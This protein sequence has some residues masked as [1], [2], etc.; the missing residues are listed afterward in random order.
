MTVSLP[1]LAL[2][3]FAIVGNATANIL[4]KHGASKIGETKGL[5]DF[6]LKAITNP[7]I[8]AGAI[9]FVVVLAA[10]SAVLMKLPLS[11]AYPLMTSFGFLIVVTASIYLFGERL[12]LPQLVGMALILIGL[13]LVARYLGMRP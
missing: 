13:W 4:I 9:L 11:I 5:V 8:L 1:T 12:H 6:G 3:T 2:L 7:S 10:Y